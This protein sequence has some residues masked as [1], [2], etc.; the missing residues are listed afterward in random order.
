MIT[1]LCKFIKADDYYFKKD[2]Y[3]VVKNKQHYYISKA[4]LQT[5]RWINQIVKEMS[6]SGN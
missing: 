3:V 1:E 4:W 5:D 6:K 2:G